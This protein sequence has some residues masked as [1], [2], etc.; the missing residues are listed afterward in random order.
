MKMKTTT[1]TTSLLQNI[2][3][4]EDSDGDVDM[5]KAEDDHKNKSKSTNKEDKKKKKNKRRKT[6]K[7]KRQRF[8]IPAGFVV[9]PQPSVESKELIHFLINKRITKN[10]L[11]EM[12][13]QGVKDMQKLF[14]RRYDYYCKLEDGR[15]HDLQEL[16]DM[17]E[18]K[19][20]YKTVAKLRKLALHLCTLN[21]WTTVINNSPLTAF[22]RNTGGALEKA[23]RM[24]RQHQQ[25]Q[26]EKKR[27]AEIEKTTVRSQ[28]KQLQDVA[29]KWHLYLGILWRA[30]QDL[31]KMT[32]EALDQVKTTSAS[33]SSSSST[34][35]DSQSTTAAHLV[36]QLQCHP[37]NQPGVFQASVR[38]LS[39][40]FQKPLPYIDS[41]CAKTDFEMPCEIW[42]SMKSHGAYTID[43]KFRKRRNGSKNKSESDSSDDEE[44]NDEEEEED[45]SKSNNKSKV[46]NSTIKEKF[47]FNFFKRRQQIASTYLPAS[48][49]VTNTILKKTFDDDRA[50]G[51]GKDA[52]DS[53]PSAA[54]RSSTG[55][56]LRNLWPIDRDSSFF[57]NGI[58]MVLDGPLPHFRHGLS[59]IS[60]ASTH[61]LHA[62]ER[63]R[64]VRDGWMPKYSVPSMPD[65]VKA[66]IND[67]PMTLSARPVKSFKCRQTRE[68]TTFRD[69]LLLSIPGGV[70]YDKVTGEPN[71]KALEI[72]MDHRASNPSATDRAQEFNSK[73]DC[74][75]M[76]DLNKD[77]DDLAASTAKHVF[78]FRTPLMD[79]MVERRRHPEQPA[80][81][82]EMR[83]TSIDG[84]FC[85]HLPTTNE[86][87]N[88]RGSL[89]NIILTV[90]FSAI[91]SAAH[92]TVVYMWLRDKGHKRSGVQVGVLPAVYNR[93]VE[94]LGVEPLMWYFP[95]M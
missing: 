10:G 49:A 5:S 21:T 30:R 45:D 82:N 69:P 18:V 6:T 22:E 38:Q 87:S 81:L 29:E 43:P 46:N 13:V 93:V 11:C 56:L 4:Q 27:S 80:P 8:I 7:Q 33:S 63:Q 84:D 15:L 53:R 48:A 90:D 57:Y 58:P 17:D 37:E 54:S 78:E 25:N 42:Q 44:D 65:V 50:A 67:T 64:L 52:K 14:G 62:K 3:D 12:I 31:E 75:T 36:A 86:A 55:K 16:T 41:D 24:L 20:K 66:E 79:L 28:V 2:H 77:S 32:Q 83:M 92:R 61:T 88:R 9:D 70:L 40:S 68:C 26:A 89:R 23:K 35:Q 91:E 1:A 19:S 60:F 72:M 76:L 95:G 94:L 51:D 73:I 47:K 71:A 34:T 74:T 39:R 59:A 85:E